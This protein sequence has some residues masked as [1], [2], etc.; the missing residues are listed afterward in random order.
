MLVRDTFDV[1]S[2]Q[3][4]GDYTLNVFNI[5]TAYYLYRLGF[6]KV[7]LSVELSLEEIRQ[8]VT[9]FQ[10]TFGVF[11]NVEVVGYG[12]VE[13][14]IIKG[15]ILDLEEDQYTYYL[16]DLRKRQF[17]V[18]YH[19]GKTMVLNYQK[20]DMHVISTLEDIVCIR[21]QFF[22]ETKEEILSIL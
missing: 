4:I 19:D 3:A 17:P 22:D 13:D 7:T 15:N 6:L 18:Y 16:E 1:S 2:Y 8:F 20:Q 11:P 12:R 5:Y 9:L 10:K 14:M 21:Y